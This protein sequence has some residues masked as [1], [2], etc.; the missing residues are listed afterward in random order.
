MEEINPTKHK[1]PE[2]VDASKAEKFKS[3]VFDLIITRMSIVSL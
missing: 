2:K 1:K 3:M